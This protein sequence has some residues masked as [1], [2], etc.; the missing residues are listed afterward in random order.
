MLAID[1]DYDEAEAEQDDEPAGLP[2]HVG[3]DVGRG[4]RL[5]WKQYWERNYAKMNKD[6]KA[7]FDVI[8]RAIE[9]S[10]SGE[11]G[12]KRFFLEGAGGTGAQKTSSILIALTFFR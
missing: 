1:V 5:T 6:Q 8:K 9:H 10:R 3:A 12:A 11:P 7:A 4:G 2:T